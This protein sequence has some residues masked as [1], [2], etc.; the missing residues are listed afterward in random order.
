MTP[1]LATVLAF[2]V[3]CQVETREESSA[4]TNKHT[5]G[6]PHALY[7]ADATEQEGAAALESVVRRRRTGSGKRQ[8]EWTLRVRKTRFGPAP[9]ETFDLASFDADPPL[10]GG[11]AV[12]PHEDVFVRLTRWLVGA[13]WP[14]SAAVVVSIVIAGFG[15]RGA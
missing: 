12:A 7:L 11:S 14:C 9:H 3:V 5:A 6:L 2:A 1:G 4:Q 15:C 10:E 13:I 8:Y